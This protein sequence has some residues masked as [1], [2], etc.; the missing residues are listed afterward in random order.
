MEAL[1]GGRESNKGWRKPKRVMGKD[2][3]LRYLYGWLVFWVI[4]V[5]VSVAVIVFW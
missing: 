5:A 4:V 2:E 1:N 3:R